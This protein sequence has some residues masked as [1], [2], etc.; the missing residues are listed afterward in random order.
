MSRSSL[1]FLSFLSRIPLCGYTIDTIF[2][3]P[4]INGHFD[5]FVIWSIM[6]KVALN[7]SVVDMDTYFSWLYT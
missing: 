7:M 5:C 6:N 3:H 2:I 4:I 1:A